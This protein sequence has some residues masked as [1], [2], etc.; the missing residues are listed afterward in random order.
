MREIG[1]ADSDGLV[2]DGIWDDFSFYVSTTSSC[3]LK[4]SLFCSVAFREKVSA[5]KAY[6]RRRL[7]S[8]LVVSSGHSIYNDLCFEFPI[9]ADIINCVVFGKYKVVVFPSRSSSSLLARV[10]REAHFGPRFRNILSGNL[11]P[12]QIRN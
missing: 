7:G 5:A 2:A 3:H 9:N 10:T 12:A 11:R 4:A 1:G 8:E 6:Q